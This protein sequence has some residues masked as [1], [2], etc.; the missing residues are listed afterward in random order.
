MIKPSVSI[1]GEMTLRVVCEE[2][3]PT[4]LQEI[5]SSLSDIH[6]GA[7]N[8]RIQD[9]SAYLI[10]HLIKNPN[11]AKKDLYR[12]AVINACLGAHAVREHPDDSRLAEIFWNGHADQTITAEGRVNHKN[13]RAVLSS[14]AIPAP[15]LREMIQRLAAH[16]SNGRYLLSIVR[17]HSPGKMLSKEVLAVDWLP[18]RLRNKIE[19]E[20]K[21]QPQ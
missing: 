17:D 20:I 10:Y 12:L 9:E 18:L 8:E 14:R 3:D 2:S 1:F 15:I 4:R 13:L 5:T 16:A 21:R 6:Y 7:S 11:L 19:D